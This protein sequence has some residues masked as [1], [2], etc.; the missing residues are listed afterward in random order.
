M[1]K[2]FGVLPSQMIREMMEGGFVSGASAANVNPASLDLSL[3]D[4][5]YR[6]EG[7][8]LPRPGEKVRELLQQMPHAPHV[9][10]D[11]L[12]KDVTYLARLNETLAFP[13]HV[14]GYCNPKSSTGRND[15]HVRV[16]A[17]G[18]SRYDMIPEGYKGEVWL[19]I[20]PNSYPIRVQQ[21]TTL[22]QLRFFNHDTRLSELEL[23]MT[24]QKDNLLFDSHGEVITYSRLKIKDGD[25]S[26][27]LRLDIEQDPLGY[28]CFGVSEAVDFSKINHYEP[29]KFFKQV[30]REGDF[31][32]LKKGGF[33]ILSS[34]EA[35]RIPPYLACEMVPMDERSGEFRSHYAGFID[36]G[37]GCGKGGE[38][39][40]RSLTL[41]VRP[42]EDMIVR[43]KQAIAKIKFERMMDI[44]DMLYDV[45]GRSNYSVQSGARLSKHFISR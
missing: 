22:V 5:M 29:G 2:K 9:F 7:V 33:Y 45:S 35:V 16:L 12:E 28:E 15:V 30:K 14:Y 38:E 17:D 39:K 8:F 41:E 42:F 43:G 3:S 11:I 44:P 18:V 19:A 1:A 4:E 10:G 40:G 37:W 13:G 32:R 6:V 20:Q 36:P 31:V 34:K 24:M 27:I 23:E 21:G 25:G 26:V